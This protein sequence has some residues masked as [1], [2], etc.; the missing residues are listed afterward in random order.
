[1]LHLRDGARFSP[2][3]I[4]GIQA[5][6][7]NLGFIRQENLVSHGQSDHW[8]L[9]HIPD[10][11]PSPTIARFGQAVSSRK[12]LGGS[13][14]LPFKNDGGHSVLGDL[15]SCLGA[16]QTHPFTFCSDMH[17]QLWDLI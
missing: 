16:L 7:F 17:S 5:K 8:V 14:L 1:M 10:Q 15:Q 12:S 11:G 2:D 4:L 3:M 9:G 6:E 13:K